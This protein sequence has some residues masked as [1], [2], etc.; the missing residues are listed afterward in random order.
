M[1]GIRSGF[2][3]VSSGLGPRSWRLKTST[4]GIFIRANHGQ[5][6]EHQFLLSSCS[7]YTSTSI[8]IEFIAKTGHF[9]RNRVFLEDVFS[10]ISY[11][12]MREFL[13]SH[14]N[15]P[16][17]WLNSS[18]LEL[19]CRQAVGDHAWIFWTRCVLDGEFSLVNGGRGRGLL[20]GRV[21]WHG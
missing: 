17:F 11:R 18:D 10:C 5:S 4:W 3:K 12:N 9:E 16:E 8:F 21:V 14:V 15:L 6:S 2:S 13:A 20:L 1:T 19:S 7:K